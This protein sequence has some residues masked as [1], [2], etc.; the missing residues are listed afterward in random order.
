MPSSGSR[1][2]RPAPS[3][4]A[5]RTVSSSSL[6]AMR[7]SPAAMTVS[8]GGFRRGPASAGRSPISAESSKA[9][10]AS[11]KVVPASS[12]MLGEVD[13]VAVEVEQ[14]RVDDRQTGLPA[15]LGD[16]PRDEVAR[17][18]ELGLVAADQAGDVH[19]RRVAKLGD[20]VVR[21]R[22]AARVVRD[23]EHRLD[24]VGIG[25]VVLGR[26]DDD[27]S[28]A[29]RARAISR[30]SMSI[31]SPERQTIEVR[32]V[33]GRRARISSSISPLSRSA[34]MTIALRLT[35]AL[36]TTSSET[37]VKISC[38]QPRMTVCPD[39]TTRERPLRSSASLPSSPVLMMPISALMMKMPNEGDGQHPEQ[40][41]ERPGVAAHRARVERPHQAV[42]QQVGDR[43]LRLRVE[44]RDDDRDEDHADGGDEEQAQD[45]GDRPAGHEVVEDV[46]DP[47]AAG[48]FGHAILMV[49]PG[50]WRRRRG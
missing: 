39:S 31:G 20:D 18:D 37:T 1:L 29:S 30:S 45:Q 9:R 19:V 15:G 11:P 38:D 44:D 28:R 49:G 33:F 32:P 50:R 46:A 23:R 22:P 10:R 43:R 25:I 41:P 17:Q 5:S 12:G 21:L 24:D 34:R 26:Q 40:E 35:F 47:L 27:R 16:D 6:I 48:G 8:I 42:P 36:A 2:R 3:L 7:W 14:L 13:L 4:L